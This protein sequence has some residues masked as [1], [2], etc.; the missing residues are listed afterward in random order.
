MPSAR[1]KDREGPEA[2]TRIERIIR[3]IG[4]AD[5]GRLRD[6]GPSLDG[7]SFAGVEERVMGDARGPWSALKDLVSASGGFGVPSKTA[8]WSGTGRRA[9]VRAPAPGV[10]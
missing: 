5:S 8:R 9:R 4:L 3:V 10:G 6:R 2:V 7:Q 1:R